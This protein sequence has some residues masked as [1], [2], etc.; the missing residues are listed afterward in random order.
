MGLG[1]GAQHQA[2]HSAPAGTACP[3]LRASGAPP[4]LPPAS[5]PHPSLSPFPASAVWLTDVS[6]SDVKPLGSFFFFFFF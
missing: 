6:Q 1:D 3:H 5:L 4:G 2:L